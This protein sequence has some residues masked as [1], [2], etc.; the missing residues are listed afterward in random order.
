[1]ESSEGLPGATADLDTARQWAIDPSTSPIALDNLYR[2]WPEVH[3]GLASNPSTPQHL[4]AE[5]ATS[6]D[7]TVIRALLSNDAARAL[8]IRPLPRWNAPVSAD[9]QP[10]PVAERRYPC[11][12]PTCNAYV[13]TDQ[14]RCT[15]CGTAL[16]SWRSGSI[17][18]DVTEVTGEM[19]VVP[20]DDYAGLTTIPFEPAASAAF[21][22]QRVDA[23]A[24]AARAAAG[25]DERIA[26]ATTGDVPVTAVDTSVPGASVPGSV[27]AGGVG[28]LVGAAAYA[29]QPPTVEQAA[30]RMGDPTELE[31]FALSP[32]PHND[33]FG[34]RWRRWT[35]KGD[36]NLDSQN[37][38]GGPV[39]T[40]A[41]P[42]WFQRVGPLGLLGVFGS[43]ALLA[44]AFLVVRAFGNNN[45]K[46][47]TTTNTK[48]V[49]PPPGSKGTAKGTAT[50]VATAAPTTAP[51][52]TDKPVVLATSETN[53]APAPDSSQA[54]APAPGP[55]TVVTTRA[56]NPTAAPTT[57]PVVVSTTAGQVVKTT[58]P[59][60]TTV[61]PTTTTVDKVAV[62]T[63][64]AG[65]I[66]QDYASALA[67]ADAATV[68]KMNPAKSSDLSGYRYLDSSTVIPV[69]VSP[70]GGSL[71]T[72][73]LGLVAQERAPSG[74]Q[75]KLFCNVWVVD[76]A[77]NQI[78]EKTG[79]S[80]RTVSGLSSASD[81]VKEL[82][83]ACA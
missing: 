8:S 75:T 11:T 28:A 48:I 77:K 41:R 80:I 27:V 35:N 61:P 5:L 76:V 40:G 57:K 43:V 16:R 50:T 26:R 18:A 82:Q 32:M 1:M 24:L 66:A 29:N 49:P 71:Y 30:M 74:N 47:A 69:A 52:S 14:H 83:K 67:R 79:R 62:D 53:P 55:A 22:D 36:Q 2:F 54:P 4:L 68:T 72:M 17:P 58:V 63:A 7:P 9:A 51:P 59:P 64:K 19:P 3:A 31:G 60:P 65:S 45:S 37:V 25:Y 15:S 38:D 20:A 13:T 23:E 70:N 33:S 6:P 12:N 10:S 21:A 44:F 78:S 56:Q 42:S 81:F 39:A 46:T 73:K 34:D